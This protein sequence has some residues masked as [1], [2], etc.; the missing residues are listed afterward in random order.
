MRRQGTFAWIN[1]RREGGQKKGNSILARECVEDPLWNDG[2][3][4]K[5]LVLGVFFSPLTTLGNRETM[6]R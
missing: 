2:K 3:G 4:D 5:S 6:N 1:E